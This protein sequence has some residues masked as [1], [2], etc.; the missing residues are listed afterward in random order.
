MSLPREI[1]HIYATRV[2]RRW[3]GHTLTVSAILAAI[4]V[5]PKAYGAI[6]GFERVWWGCGLHRCSPSPTAYTTYALLHAVVFAAIAWAVGYG[7]ARRRFLQQTDPHRTTSAELLAARAIADDEERWS[8]AA[9]LSG[10]V[11]VLPFLV[12]YGVAILLGIARPHAPTS[13]DLG[14]WIQSRFAQ[15][16]YAYAFIALSAWRYGR[17]IERENRGWAA[18]LDKG[19]I[20]LWMLSALSAMWCASTSA[21]F[22][23][24]ALFPLSA[25]ANRRA[26]RERA[27]LEAASLPS[28]EADRAATFDSLA[29][30]AEDERTIPQSARILALRALADRFTMTKVGPVLDRM[31]NPWSISI[32]RAVVE[33]A[34]ENHHRL[35][36]ARVLEA[37]A[38]TDPYILRG[39][40]RVLKRYRDPGV[41]PALIRLLD[42]EDR[43]VTI[44]AVES[45]GYIGT[46][47]AV[48]PIRFRVQRIGGRELRGTAR[49]AIQ[50][51]H[52]RLGPVERGR[53]SLSA[54]EA[55]E[56]AVS[57]SDGSG[58]LSVAD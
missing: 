43:A 10:I 38:S 4:G 39:T 25:W 16:W 33:I 54:V 19:V 9:L 26:K 34:I 42:S 31:F 41:Q 48:G 44:E 14:V 36:L 51:I 20:V 17:W 45:L 1:R 58:S 40:A 29:A 46:P 12:R 35:P 15:A 37:T 23:L 8:F 56:G 18:N 50:R 5:T 22:A 21:G 24:F 13:D 27:R 32:A 53:L 11:L 7:F 2:A 3:S 47:D 57:V 52:D 6:F 55:N 30:V 28:L 49:L